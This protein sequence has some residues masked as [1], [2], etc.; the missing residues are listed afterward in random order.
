MSIDGILIVNKPPGRTSRW[1][2]DAVV[3]LLHEKKAGHLGTLDPI[4]TGVLPIVLGRAT[5]LIRYLEQEDKVYRGVVRLGIATDTQD[6]V[7][8]VLTRG[9]CAG[10]TRDQVEAA[11]QTFV[12]AITQVP[13]MHSAI[14]QGGRPLYQL[15][16][17]GIEVPREP[18]PVTV[19]ALTVEA[20]AS[21]DVT[22]H[23]RC[24]PGTY[25]RTIAH[26]LGRLLGCG[27]HL[28]S[29][30][31]LASGPFTI[32]EAIDLDGLDPATAL[33]RM[34]PLDDCLP[35]LPALELT[36]TQ[37]DLVRDG[38]YLLPPEG[39]ELQPRQLYRLTISSH[40]LAIASA[41]PHGLQLMLHPLRVLAP[42]P[43]RRN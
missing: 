6:A 28:L 2:T 32:D 42:D 24:S 26:D 20:F 22:V 23:V 5:R 12:G 31:R 27:G 15:A 40:L 16:R 43:P 36:P 3:R 14:K 35:H 29:L 34:I 33:A 18:R 11:A 17:E 38:A 1:T 10:V 13:P 21:P 19:Y 4:A 41:E 9:D 25:L 8:E 30:V 39:V 37:A 7:G